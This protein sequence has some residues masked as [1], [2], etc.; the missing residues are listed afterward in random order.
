LEIQFIALWLSREAQSL[1]HYTIPKTAA[2]ATGI[3]GTGALVP[4]GTRHNFAFV[5]NHVPRKASLPFRD[6]DGKLQVTKCD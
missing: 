2:L 1:I 5:F 4:P 6:T 3:G